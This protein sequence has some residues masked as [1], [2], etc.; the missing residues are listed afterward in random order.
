M[1]LVVFMRLFEVISYV[2]TLMVPIRVWTVKVY[3]I[4]IQEMRT[5][6]IF[7]KVKPK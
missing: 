4:K 1:T 3:F 2:C 5:L 7:N 6:K